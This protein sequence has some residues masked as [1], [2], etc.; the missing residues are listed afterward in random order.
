MAS[1]ANAPSL[2]NVDGL[3]SLSSVGYGALRVRENPELENL[4]GLG[5]INSVEEQI[6][7]TN[8]SKLPDCEIC[9]LL[10]SIYSGPLP[11]AVIH[12]N[13]EDCCTPVP[14]NCP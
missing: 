1:F 8:N 3:C 4:D 11:T 7:I 12:S 2:R 14:D 13:R 5:G 9:G 6:E 10:R